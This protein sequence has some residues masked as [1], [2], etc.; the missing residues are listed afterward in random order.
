M[1]RERC[2]TAPLVGE[3]VGDAFLKAV[4]CTGTEAATMARP[5]V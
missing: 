3:R 1:P 2:F 5:G 4:A